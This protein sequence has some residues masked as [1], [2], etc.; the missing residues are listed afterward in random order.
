MKTFNEELK[1]FEMELDGCLC[2]HPAVE[3]FFTKEIKELVSEVEKK[4][5]HHGCY[6]TGVMRNFDYVL[7]DDITK[8]IKER[9]G[10]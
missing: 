4:K 2:Y 9:F 10:I 1:E 8:L 6:K 5:E 3:I 7:L